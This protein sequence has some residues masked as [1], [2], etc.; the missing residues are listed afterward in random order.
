MGRTEHNLVKPTFTGRLSNIAPMIAEKNL[1]GK[2]CKALRPDW[3]RIGDPTACGRPRLDRSR[4][5]W[6]H[7]P[8]RYYAQA[9]K[10]RAIRAQN[11]GDHAG[12]MSFGDVALA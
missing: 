4:L 9:R 12:T 3:D 8:F 5:I 10:R 6:A 1:I 2:P 11:N 7:F